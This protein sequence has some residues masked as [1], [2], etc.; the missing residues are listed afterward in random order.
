MKWF[1]IFVFVAL[2]SFIA[3]CLNGKENIED[4][5]KKMSQTGDVPHYLYFEGEVN[6][7]G[8][9]GSYNLSYIYPDTLTVFMDLSIIKTVQSLTG[10][11]G[12]VLQNGQK[13]PMGEMEI[14]LAKKDVKI[15]TMQWIKDKDKLK[16]IGK[17]KWEYQI[18]D[19]NSIIL[20][21][22]KDG[23]LI[24]SETD[25]PFGKS[26]T[27]YS[28]YKVVNGFAIPFTVKQVLGPQVMTIKLKNVKVNDPSPVIVNMDDYIKEYKDAK[29]KY[30]LIDNHIFVNAYINGHPCRL[31]IDTGAGLTVIDK[32]FGE[33][34]GIKGKGEMPAIGM[35]KDVQSGYLSKINLKID[36]GEWNDVVCVVMDLSSVK[37]AL[38]EKFDGVV[39]YNVLGHY[40][41]SFDK[42]NNI[43]NL[44]REPFLEGY[45]AVPLVMDFDLPAI[46]V[47]IKGNVYTF[48][49]DTGAGMS[50]FSDDLPVKLVDKTKDVVMS[51]LGGN[52]KGKIGILTDWQIGGIKMDDLMGVVIP[53]SKMPASFEGI[54]GMD[55]ILSHD[56]IINYV[57]HSLY[58]RR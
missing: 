29:L 23:Y 51:G 1:Y 39:G 32:S 48:R 19:K 26:Y 46:K 12:I 31:L 7:A 6:V 56:V 20:Y 33:K 28:D 43:L 53:R 57:D 17:R 54:L 16:N 11:E 52:E 35:G 41:I 25:T 14:D 34:Y 30:E 37:N 22:S 9:N 50:V 8:M 58:I 18:D 21:F 27:E 10:N 15:T 3:G 4:Y 45:T 24:R 36:G 47:N 40:A 42:E 2:A 49:I 38:K 5:I 44:E 55:W 13:R